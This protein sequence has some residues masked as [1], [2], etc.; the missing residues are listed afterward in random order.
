L[1]TVFC[2]LQAT[3]QRRKSIHKNMTQ[4]SHMIEQRCN[5]YAHTDSINSN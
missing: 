3:D 2:I 1:A 4:I 5:I